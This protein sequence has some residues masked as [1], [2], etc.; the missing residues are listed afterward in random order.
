MREAEGQTIRLADYRAPDF[1]IDSVDLDF[2]LHTN[3]TRVG[4]TLT[5]RRND[6]ADKTAALDL[7]GDELALTGLW[8]DGKPLGPES[9]EAT[10]TRLRVFTPPGRPFSLRIETRLDPAKNTKLMGLYRSG[11]AY[12]TQCEA[13]GFRRIT[14]FLDRPDVMSIYRVRLEAD[15]REAPVLLS[16]GNFVEGG[17]AETPGRH[18]A[19]W[20]DPHKKP[21]YLFALVAGDLAAVRDHHVTTSG[22]KVDLAIYVEHGREARA[23][24]AMDSLKRSFAWDERAFGREYDLEQFNVVAVSDFNMG[25]M[26]NKGLNVFNDK[27]VLAAPETATDD[28]YA[29]IESVIG[30]EY[31]H[32]WTGNRITCR[33][34]FQLCLKEGLTVFRDQEF[35]S[36]ERSRAVKRIADVRTLRAAQF[37][38]DSGPLAHSVRP[39][40]YREINNFY[41]ATVYQKGAEVIRMLKAIIGDDAFKRGMDLY[42]ARCDGTAATVEDFLAC[43]AESSGRDL[44]AFKRWYEQA[45]TPRVE[46]RTDFADGTLTVRLSQ[47]LAPT[48]GQPTKA[49]MP[50]PIAIGLI[51]GDAGPQALQS[52]DATAD[53]IARGV[54]V[55][56][57]PHRTLRFTGLKRRPTLSAL[58]GFS[59]PVRVDDDL[60]DDDLAVLARKDDDPFNRWQSLQSQAI[61]ACVAG[62]V[63]IRA[64][65]A[66][67]DAARLAGAFAATLADALAGRIDP[68]FAALALAL[69]SEGDLAREI[70]ADIDPDAIRAA[71]VAL[72]TAIGVH[73]AP[74]LKEALAR[75]VE[76]GAFSPDAKAA[77]RRALKNAALTLLAFAD[78]DGGGRLAESQADHATNMTDRLG[79]LA[80]LVFSLNP[81]RE[82]ALARFEARFAHEPLVMDKW[83]A[84]SAMIP[85]DAA[86]ERVRA[87]FAHP[88]FSFAN[89]NRVRALVSGFTGNQTQ[90]NRPDGA[91][92]ALLAD[93]V[94]KLDPQNPQIAARLLTAMRV[95]RTFEPVRRA[96]AENALRRIAAEPNLST[97][98]SDIVTRSLG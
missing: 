66:P 17:K 74:A 49:P 15:E 40:I 71:R 84:L 56:D 82:G 70:G 7:V 16:N 19:I 2:D 33:D 39:A 69:P 88:A 54:F 27:Y 86:L 98:L 18:Y 38:E 35:S 89:P 93:V 91:G 64:G 63:A 68:A 44:S 94:L 51:D 77:G 60:T 32:N 59:A 4:A 5:I 73:N 83:F 62:V 1:W 92:Y 20:S 48:P 55:L 81:R 25:A 65:G 61:R 47:S 26:E 11:S 53:E 50:I 36:D 9:Y 8:L 10:P 95:W 46:I 96:A 42:F 41:T 80:A 37:P 14:Y 79:A 57:G 3:A 67:P 78:L 21:C 97:D 85:D 13:E 34:W 12:C 6:Q 23:L 76:T 22:A 30:H 28:D 45:G 90:F 58:R 43:F 72:M 87:L 29:Q 52:A 75:F 24:Y 31:F